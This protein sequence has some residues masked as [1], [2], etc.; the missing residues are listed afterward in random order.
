MACRTPIDAAQEF[1]HR[2]RVERASQRGN[3]LVEQVHA[4]RGVD[5]RGAMHLLGGIEPVAAFGQCT[6]AGRDIGGDGSGDDHRKA[7]ADPVRARP[8]DP[9]PGRFPAN[10][11]GE[12]EAP[13]RA[14]VIS[15]MPA[16]PQCAPALRYRVLEMAIPH[17]DETRR[18]PS[19][20][21]IPGTGQLS[22]KA[23]GGIR[24]ALI[25]RTGNWTRRCSGTGSSGCW[26]GSSPS[27]HG[28][29]N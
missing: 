18:Q 25:P 17:V 8:H 12:Q 5:L 20:H 2:R 16:A 11:R 22:E 7:A 4:D 10:S 26:P 3:P 24:H 6:G 9:G 19:L 21:E 14:G 23:G 29:R 13:Y 1:R 28:R 15:L 27:P